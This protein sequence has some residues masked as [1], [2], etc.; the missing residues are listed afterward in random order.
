MEFEM[1]KEFD[2]GRFQEIVSNI[3]NAL[4]KCE[5]RDD[6]LMSA[7]YMMTCS[8]KIFSEVF[9]S[10]ELGR[11]FMVDYLNGP[12]NPDELKKIV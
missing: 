12:I 3:D 6:F 9:G 11:A 1:E 5:S 10:E 2:H 4:D 7:S 8:K